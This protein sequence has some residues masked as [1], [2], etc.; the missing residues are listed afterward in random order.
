M[1][2]HRSIHQQWL[3][4]AVLSIISAIGRDE[5]SGICI[6]PLMQTT[7]AIIIIII[8][9]GKVATVEVLGSN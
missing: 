7:I 4:I 9:K 3:F 1:R 6:C 8:E 5:S 2:A